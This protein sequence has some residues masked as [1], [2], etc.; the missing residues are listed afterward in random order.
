MTILVVYGGAEVASLRQDNVGDF[1]FLVISQCGSSPRN[2]A[3]YT[4]SESGKTKNTVIQRWPMCVTF[5]VLSDGQPSLSQ[6]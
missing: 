6:W 4:M 5:V 3:A 2:I 1:A